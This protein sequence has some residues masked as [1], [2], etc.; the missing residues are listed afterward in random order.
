[1]LLLLRLLRAT[2]SGF[3][4]GLGDDFCLRSAAVR[5]SGWALGAYGVGLLTRAVAASTQSIRRFLIS[6]AVGFG[7]LREAFRLRRISARS[8]R[9]D[10]FNSQSPALGSASIMGP[11]PGS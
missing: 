1:M 10:S 5:D 7:P 11:C 6:S 3:E 9:S 2:R 4:G 8:L